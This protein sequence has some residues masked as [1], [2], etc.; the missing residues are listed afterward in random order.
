MMITLLPSSQAIHLDV[1]IPLPN[2]CLMAQALRANLLLKDIGHTPPPQRREPNSHE[3]DDES[4]TV[5]EDSQALMEEQVDLF[6][7]HTPH[8][9]LY[10]ADFDLDKAVVN[11]TDAAGVRD[12]LNHTRV[13]ALLKTISSINFTD[14]VN[15][16]ECPL[17][18]TTASNDQSSP[19]QSDEYFSLN[20]DQYYIINGDYIMLPVKNTPC[21]QTLSD[22]LLEPLQQYLKHPI[23]I[24]S[25]VDSLPEPKRSE[26]ISATMRYGSPNV[27]GGFEPHVTVGYD[28][29]AVAS[30]SRAAAC[31]SGQCL[32]YTG[33]C[34]TEVN[35]FADPCDMMECV[36]P[37][38]C[39]ANY[40]GGCNASC[41]QVNTEKNDENTVELSTNEETSLQMR[42][43]AMQQWNDDYQ[44][45]HEGCV[46]QVEGI[47]VGRNGIGGTVITGSRMKYWS[48]EDAKKNTV[49]MSEVGG[50]A[51]EI[52]A[53]V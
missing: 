34:Q 26:K 45:I 4:T 8:I 2:G 20:T 7:R 22:A 17:S 13:D 40:C 25:W 46:D 52:Y 15:V 44:L 33:T 51:S 11:S 3:K 39:R 41:E 29:S 24:P 50:D 9:T 14:I 48:L 36:A 21:L 32:D 6:M 49:L 47:A 1:H 35:C 28:P 38:V 16:S 12:E 19:K 5:P 31:P 42:V 43:E 23:E 27:L 18:F 10:L 37:K 30:N 53:S